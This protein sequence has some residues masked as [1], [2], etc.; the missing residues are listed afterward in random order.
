[1]EMNEKNGW[2]DG[3]GGILKST[4][5]QSELCGGG[6]ESGRAGS[7][8]LCRTFGPDGLSVGGHQA[9]PHRSVGQR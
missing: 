1:M 6:G 9:A 3:L 5:T 7:D 8:A 4:H 2:M